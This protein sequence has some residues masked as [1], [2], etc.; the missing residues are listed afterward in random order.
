MA[1]IAVGIFGIRRPTRSP[2]RQPASLSRWP[3]RFLRH[4]IVTSDEE[5]T[6]GLVVLER[7]QPVRV[8]RSRFGLPELGEL[9]MPGRIRDFHG[10]L[11]GELA[12]AVFRVSRAS[13]RPGLRV[14]GTR[15]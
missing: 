14:F 8:L 11:V 6:D 1:T 4:P 15:D 7:H 13:D 10:E 9:L 12:L 5:G 3:S 2:R